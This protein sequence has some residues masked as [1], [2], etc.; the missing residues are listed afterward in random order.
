VL[1]HFDV[2]ENAD[3]ETGYL[4]TAWQSKSYSDG[5]VVIRTRVIIKRT[6]SDPLRY[7]VKL[8]SERSKGAGASVR[9]DD[10][11][12]PWDRVLAGYQG[13]IG[14]LQAKLP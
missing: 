11:F 3:R 9:D 10:S 1:S 7:T 6:S 12:A 14:E 13:L 2:L 8:A 4:R 5:A